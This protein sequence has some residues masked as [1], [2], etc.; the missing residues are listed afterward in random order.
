MLYILFAVDLL[1]ILQMVRELQLYHTKQ[2]EPC[3]STVIV[4]LRGEEPALGMNATSILGQ[5]HPDF[6]LIYVVDSDELEKQNARLKQFG[7]QAIETEELCGRCSGKIRAILTGIR[8]SNGNIVI[9]DSD[10][11][12]P[13]GWLAALT[14]MLKNYHVVTVFS[15]PC[16]LK[17]TPSNLMRAGFWTLGFESHAIGGRFLWG[18]SMAFREGDIDQKITDELSVEWCDDCALTRISKEKGWKIGY[19][20]RAMPLN[21]FDERAL[22]SWTTRQVKLMLKYSRKGVY[23][24]AAVALILTAFLV[25]FALTANWLYLTPFALWVVKNLVRGRRYGRLAVLPSIMSVPA[26]FFALL[27]LVVGA[28]S[29]SVQWRDR[30]YYVDG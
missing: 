21:A 12:Y 28:R 3:K 2:G 16:L 27:F 8:H 9:A 13:K 11:V 18:G 5:E 4:P 15:W 29:H 26:I 23:V 14:S 1:L 6:K 17:I 25:M 24:F 7:V 10:T 30:S 19:A 20:A 22:A